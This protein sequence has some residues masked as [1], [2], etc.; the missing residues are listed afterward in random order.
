MYNILHLINRAQFLL[1]NSLLI[2]LNIT[3]FTNDTQ[4]LLLY[5]HLDNPQMIFDAIYQFMMSISF[6]G[7]Q[8]NEFWNHDKA[9][10]YNVLYLFSLFTYV[11]IAVKLFQT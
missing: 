8:I 2:Y 5:D 10:F 6:I 11:Y 9:S 1:Y 4:I 7:R 3:Y